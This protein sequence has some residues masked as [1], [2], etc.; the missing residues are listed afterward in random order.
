MKSREKSTEIQIW[1]P[2]V[3]VELTNLIFVYTLTIWCIRL[4]LSKRLENALKKCCLVKKFYDVLKTTR[5]IGTSNLFSTGQDVESYVRNGTLDLDCNSNAEVI[6]KLDE[7]FSSMGHFYNN[8]ME[9]V[10]MYK[11]KAYYVGGILAQVGKRFAE[12]APKRDPPITGTRNIEV[13]VNNNI[14]ELLNFCKWDSIVE[15]V[16]EDEE[17]SFIGASPVPLKRDFFRQWKC[18]INKFFNIC[19]L[20]IKLLF[21]NLSY[22]TICKLFPAKQQTLEAIITSIR[23][24]SDEFPVFDD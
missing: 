9:L 5:S 12:E 20:E 19:K 10:V 15:A 18:R 14:F 8:Q 2:P 4:E 7:V 21:T 1:C 24:R 23:S 13:Y 11:L 22:S 17:L 6:E 16:G 3:S